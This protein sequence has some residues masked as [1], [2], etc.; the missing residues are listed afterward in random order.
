MKIALKGLPEIKNLL[1]MLPESMQGT[2]TTRFFHASAFKGPMTLDSN[3]GGG[4]KEWYAVINLVTGE[5]LP[6]PES[7]AMGQ[8]KAPV[9]AALPTNFAV[10]MTGVFLGKPTSAT[11]YFNPENLSP[12]LT[13]AA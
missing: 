4:T 11:I 2:F 1:K 8:R 3:W 7:G 10:V 5:L 6:L 12:M 13:A 9:L